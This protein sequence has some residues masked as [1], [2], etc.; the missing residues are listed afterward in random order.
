MGRLLSSTPVSILASL[1]LYV[2]ALNPRIL[3]YED[4]YMYTRTL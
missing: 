3:V 1:C 2:W 4:I